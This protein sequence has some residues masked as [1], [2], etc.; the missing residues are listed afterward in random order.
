M[1][2]D[3]GLF[4]AYFF[5][6]ILEGTALSGKHHFLTTLECYR[7][8]FCRFCCAS[9]WRAFWEWSV[10]TTD[11]EESTDISGGCHTTSAFG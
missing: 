3:T 9:L 1:R 8:F 6:T 2:R 5:I 11:L 4:L 7:S 10:K